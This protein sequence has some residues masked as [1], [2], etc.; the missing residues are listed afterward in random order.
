MSMKELLAAVQS[1]AVSPEQARDRLRERR[2]A[3]RDRLHEPIAIIGMSGR[4]PRAADLNEYWQLLVQGRD[5]VEEI[6]ATRWHVEDYYD[7]TPPRDGK[8]YAKWLGQLD[9]IDC[10]DPLFF[11][12]SPGEARYMDPQ[13]RLFMEEAWRA[14]EDA[15]YAGPAL[16]GMRCGVYFGIMSREYAELTSENPH[17]GA[18]LTGTSASIGAARIAYHL[19]LKGPAI[20][21]DTA[22]SSSLVAT[23]LACQALRT[24]EIDMALTGGA[25]V[26]ISPGTYVG[27]CAA[28]ML[29]PSG[30]CRAFDAAADGFVPGEGVGALVLKRLSDA[31]ADRDSIHGLI[32]A[33]GI[34]Q[35][36]KTNGITAPSRSSQIELTRTIYRQYGIEPESLSY[37]EMHGTGTNLGDPIELAALATTFREW[38]PRRNFCAIGSVKSNLGHTSAAA[39]VAGIH[40]VLLCM[41]R[42]MLAPT[43]HFS[44]P[45]PHFDFERSPFFVNTQS[46]P[47]PR[48]QAHARRAAVSSFGYSGTNAHLV[49]EEYRAPQPAERSPGP[50]LFVL[51]AFDEDAL[52]RSAAALA[53]YL[54]DH[55]AVD[56]DGA[57]FTLQIGRAQLANRLATVVSSHEELLMRLDAFLQRRDESGLLSGNGEPSRLVEMLAGRDDLPAMQ[58]EWFEHDPQRLLSLWCKGLDVDW[59]SLRRQSRARRIGLPTYRFA[60]ERYWLDFGLQKRAPQVAG[61]TRRVSLPLTGEE[62]YLDGHRIGGRRVLPAAQCLEIVRATLAGEMGED[63]PPLELAGVVWQRPVIVDESTDAAHPFELQISLVTRSDGGWDFSV[64]AADA[65]YCSG[66]ARRIDAGDTA[67]LP[68]CSDGDEIAVDSLYALFAAMGIHYAAANRGLLKLRVN[69]RHAEAWL[70]LPDAAPCDPKSALHPTL[71]DSALQATLGL[72]LACADGSDNQGGASLPFALDAMEVFRPTTARMRARLQA[73]PQ[74]GELRRFDLELVN[75]D[76]R[77][78]ARLRGFTSRTVRAASG[79]ATARLELLQPIWRHLPSESTAAPA[80]PEGVVWLIGADEAQ[81]AALRERHSQ[82]V[83]VFDASEATGDEDAARLR[84]ALARAGDRV[85]T[86]YWFVAPTERTRTDPGAGVLRLF[87]VIKALLASGAGLNSLD[88]TVLTVRSQAVHRFETPD[89]SSGD[90]AGQTRSQLAANFED[91][92]SAASG[93]AFVG[94][95]GTMAKEYPHWRVRVIDAD[96][97]RTWRA[98]ELDTAPALPGGAACAWREGRWWAQELASVSVEGRFPPAYRQCGLYVVVGGAGGVGEAWTKWM[99]QRYDAQVIWLGRR[100]ED[101]TI[102]ARLDRLSTIGPRPCYLQADA[103]DAEALTAALSQIKARFGTQRVINGVVHSALVL[104]DRSLAQMSERQLHDSLRPKVHASVNLARVFAG[105][106][107]DFMLFFS[108]MQS[109][110]CAAGQGNYAAGCTFQ[111]AFARQLAQR[112]RCAVKVVNWGYWGEVGIVATAEHRERMARVGL[113]SIDAE[114]GMHALELLLAAP[115]P[116]LAVLETLTP[117]VVQSLCP[118]G[119]QIT[120][121]APSDPSE[122]LRAVDRRA[123]LELSLPRELQAAADTLLAHALRI[124][125]LRTQQQVAVA[126]LAELGAQVDPLYRGW[127][128][129]S[130]RVLQRYAVLGSHD[131]PRPIAEPI[132]AAWAE[133]AAQLRCEPAIAMAAHTLDALPLILQGKV[134]ATDI[135]FRDTSMEQVEGVYRGTVVADYY[136]SVLCDELLQHCER[137]CASGENLRILEIGAGTGGTSALLFERLREWGQTR[138]PGT[139]LIEEYLYTDLSRAFLQH[140]QTHFCPHN[141]YIRCA[142]FDVEKPLERQGIAAGSYDAVVAT[143]VLHATRDIRVTLRN[144]KAALKPGGVLLLNE[145]SRSSLFAH[146]TFGLLKG[147]WL[148]QDTALRIEGSPALAPDTWD[149][150]LRSEGFAPVHFP[151]ATAHEWG[152]QVIVAFSDGVV[153]QAATEAQTDAAPLPV[154]VAATSTEGTVARVHSNPSAKSLRARVL[155]LLSGVAGKVLG[156]GPERLNPGTR[157]ER[158]GLDSI[159]AIQMAAHL[160]HYLQGVQSTLFIEH[161]TLDALATHLLTTRRDDL[162]RVLGVDA[163]APVD[164][165]QPEP[166]ATVPHPTT[167]PRSRPSDGAASQAIAIVAIS[168]RFPRA[169]SVETLWERLRDGQD[170]LEEVPVERWNH[171]QYFDADRNRLGKTNCRWGGFVDGIDEFDP[172]FFGIT[173]A[174]ADFMDP[175]VRLFLQTTWHLLEQGGYTRSTLEARHGSRVGVFVGAMYQQYQTL[176]MDYVTHAGVS[177]S[178]YSQICNRVSNFFDFKG[179]SVAVDTQCSS[180]LIAVHMARQSL[181]CGECDL[182]VAGAVNLILSPKKYLGLS[183]PLML[184]SHE[185]CRTFALGDGFLPS[186]GVGAVLLKPL[187][188]AMQ[189]GDPILA[190]IRGTAQNHGGRALGYGTQDAKA[191]YEVISRCLQQAGTPPR[192]ISVVEA[193]SNGARVPD[194]LEVSA[195]KRVFAEGTADE[196]FCTIGSVKSNLGHSESASGMAQLA[197]VLMQLR[198]G[199]LPPSILVEPANPD[200]DLSRGPFRLQRELVPWARPRLPRPEGGVVEMPR[201]ALIDSFGGGGSLACAVLEEF[202]PELPTAVA[203][204]VAL[205]RPFTEP[206]ASQ[207]I[208]LSA[209]TP[210]RLRVVVQRLLDHLGTDSNLVLADIAYTLQVAREAMS[211]RLAFIAASIEELRTRLNHIAQ[212]TDATIENAEVVIWQGTGQPQGESVRDSDQPQ[213]AEVNRWI[214]E[215]DL[216]ALARYWCAADDV[217]WAA[218]HAGTCAR[219]V[220][221]PGYP[222][223]R[224]RCWLPK[225]ASTGYDESIRRI[226]AGFTLQTYE[227]DLA[228][229]VQAEL[230]EML[231]LSP[232]EL[233]R[234]DSF[235]RLELPQVLIPRVHRHLKAR[236]GVVLGAAELAACRTVAD[237]LALLPPIETGAAQGRR[238]MSPAAAVAPARKAAKKRATGK[239]DRARAGE[240]IQSIDGRPAGESD[241]RRSRRK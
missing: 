96:T 33:S 55:P 27:M 26:Y 107:L 160:N 69:G 134:K 154:E 71:L 35:D 175:Q 225:S 19:N 164:E 182:A 227:D 128:D 183:I 146:L 133:C 34:N 143:N 111:D 5:A 187:V 87:T 78:C 16:S 200:I 198:H 108:S 123:A 118:S 161:Q 222:F 94:L 238:A 148:A 68:G 102:R 145:I 44:T 82:I 190:V 106:P 204:E 173:P 195:L 31:Q 127:L 122:R 7:P 21:I 226:D 156:L 66:H 15:G 220:S 205:T 181:L 214:A 105:E 149:R 17:L 104:D 207:L 140:A 171:S 45:N 11:G 169:D 228:E 144:A 166:F 167:V 103:S 218:L 179:P 151:A 185:R 120:L 32:I 139:K 56:L 88:W 186:E 126:S 170:C 119:E 37:V 142:L 49:L 147:W 57:A 159:L 28:G 9:D 91:E 18:S 193:A 2:P 97:Y 23:H 25:S 172:L 60:R 163:T 13:Q 41:Q 178:S 215:R 65:I 75:E 73:A 158:Y 184:G 115:L 20:P 116:Q 150:V 74:R 80:P 62:F 177:L 61:R 206:R 188:C 109:F 124:Q 58:G 40:K 168:G 59:C 3:Q 138:G 121:R 38:T 191:P 229:R 92:A 64:G 162:A 12:I 157:L 90:C 239:S 89:S 155:E 210:E 43:L 114:E 72:A 132:E 79:S 110:S 223:E 39:G 1:G 180:A 136:N 50:Y 98:N 83:R 237:I 189:D 199:L 233:A 48:P 53:L 224:R 240:A 93:A 152:Q 47:W 8:M 4:Y 130:R 101:D 230:A 196:G 112:H 231:G 6:P 131:A 174:E 100:A 197:K 192:S 202:A 201:R 85:K 95:L 63:C 36:G 86:I 194:A 212:N 232:A 219:I 135:L 221:L 137:R 29:S 51:S 117:S 141:P 22:C 77:L 209:R 76:D 165:Q 30:R 113:G 84:A 236:L 125:L 234:D 241:R 211:S 42:G 213:S 208:V 81:H 203:S 129:E 46:I 235:G 70:G 176:E 216:P 99:L 217:N 54:R 10:F 24:R 153:R 67:E 52:R 14:F